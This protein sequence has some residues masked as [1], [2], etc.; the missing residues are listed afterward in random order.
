MN[1]SNAEKNWTPEAGKEGL[2]TVDVLQH[3]GKPTSCVSQTSIWTVPFYGEPDFMW[4]QLNNFDVPVTWL[5][6]VHR[7]K[8]CDED[9]GVDNGI[10]Y[11]TYTV[12]TYR[13]SGSALCSLC[14]IEWVS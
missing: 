1:C 8:Q 12:A 10:M 7:T 9:V 3:C 13:Q 6:P 11:S 14:S 4:I 2:F 5:A